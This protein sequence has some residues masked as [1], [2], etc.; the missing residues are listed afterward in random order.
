MRKN[1][2][3]SGIWYPASVQHGE[4]PDEVAPFAEFG[5]PEGEGFGG[6]GVEVVAEAQ[7]TDIGLLAGGE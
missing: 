4:F 3:A 1:Y 7:P 2:P 6:G 5:V